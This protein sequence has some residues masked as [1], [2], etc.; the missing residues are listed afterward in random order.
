MGVTG[1]CSEACWAWMSGICS[2][3]ASSKIPGHCGVAHGIV[4]SRRG[5]LE[6][7]INP[8]RRSGGRYAH[9]ADGG[10]T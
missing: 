10:R 9:R 8:R 1:A 6:R 4:R 2:K 3:A 7:H 5:I